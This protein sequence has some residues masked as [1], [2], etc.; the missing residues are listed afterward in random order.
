MQVVVQSCRTIREASI[1]V[2]IL[3]VQAAVLCSM[4]EMNH[5]FIRIAI[6]GCTE[7]DIQ[8]LFWACHVI[9]SDAPCG[10]AGVLCPLKHG[11]ADA[12]ARARCALSPTQ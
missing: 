10:G 8:T 9:P 7:L 11:K 12:A 3:G 6:L 1:I 4:Q 2:A 5:G